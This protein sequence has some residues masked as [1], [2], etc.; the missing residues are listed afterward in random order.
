MS[1]FVSPLSAIARAHDPAF[2]C[3][4]NGGLQVVHNLEIIC[5]QIAC[6]I[7]EFAVLVFPKAPAHLVGLAEREVH[8]LPLIPSQTIWFT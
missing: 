2:Q 6:Q 4:G 5:T 7:G 8:M 3:H 1:P